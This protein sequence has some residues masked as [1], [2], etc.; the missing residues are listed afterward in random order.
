VAAS[1]TTV[2]RGYTGTQVFDTSGSLTEGSDRPICG[3]VGGASTWINVVPERDGVLHLN[4][5]GSSYDTVMAVFVGAGG[6]L[7]QLAACDNNTGLDGR[8]SA[9]N[10]P[11]QAGKTNYVVVDGVGGA[12][13]TLRFNYS[14]VTPSTLTALG[15]AQD[16]NFRLRVTGRPNMRFRIQRTATLTNWAAIVTTNSASGVFNFVDGTSTNAPRRFY[17]ALMLP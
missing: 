7:L 14:L 17:R 13:G 3:V 4:T 8:D 5:D 16:G 15:L 2:V 11:V 9:L 10:L 6:G 1:P 12:T